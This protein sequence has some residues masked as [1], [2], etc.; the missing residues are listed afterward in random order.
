MSKGISATVQAPNMKDVGNSGPVIQQK[1]SEI[2]RREGR[3]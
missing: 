2:I 1:D 3:F